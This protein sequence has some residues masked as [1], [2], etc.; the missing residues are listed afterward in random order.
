MGKKH[1]ICILLKRFYSSVLVWGKGLK[2]F[3]SMYEVYLRGE[4]VPTYENLVKHH[5]QNSKKNH[6][7]ANY[8]I[9][10]R[11][12]LKTFAKQFNF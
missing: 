1:L 10:V 6:C 8:N 11:H 9:L 12:S 7:F 4:D 5:C 3:C 2:I